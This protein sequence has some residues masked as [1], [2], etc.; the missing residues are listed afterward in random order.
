MFILIESKTFWKSNQLWKKPWKADKTMWSE[1]TYLVEAV[2][3]K[4]TISRKWMITFKI[5][6]S[7]SKCRDCPLG[8]I[9]H[10]QDQDLFRLTRLTNTLD[11]WQVVLK[12][13]F[14]TTSCRY[15]K[16]ISLKVLFV[17]HIAAI[18]SK[19]SKAY[20]LTWLF[21]LEF[22]DLTFLTWLFWLDCLTWLFYLTATFLTWLFRLDCFD[23]TVLT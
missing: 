9:D 1:V 20:C 12:S 3:W 16:A 18:S 4:N 7:W 14:E 2:I 19:F 5:L 10:C 22:F 11:T 23:L 6:M 8:L 21:W 15:C 17:T 13:N